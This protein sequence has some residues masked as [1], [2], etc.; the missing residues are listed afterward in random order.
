M[1]AEDRG[2]ERRQQVRH[3]GRNDSRERGTND[4]RN[5]QI[6]DVA[7]EQELFDSAAS[8]MPRTLGAWYSESCSVGAGMSCSVTRLIHR[9]LWAHVDRVGT[10]IVIAS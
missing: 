2:D 9:G 10:A 3:E 8:F 4:H 1:L 6:N 5:R 7:A